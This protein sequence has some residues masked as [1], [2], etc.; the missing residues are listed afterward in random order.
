MGNV[1][2]DIE[3]TPKSNSSLTSDMGNVNLDLISSAAVHLKFATSMGDVH[4][5]IPAGS[6]NGGGPELDVSSHMGNVTI[7]KNKKD[8]FRCSGRTSKSLSV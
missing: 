7:R 1:S 4:S 5:Q 8:S 6:I 2:A 3:I